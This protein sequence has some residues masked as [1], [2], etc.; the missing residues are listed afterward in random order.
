MKGSD[1]PLYFFGEETL[2]ASRSVPCMSE[3]IFVKEGRLFVLFESAC[4][5]YKTFVRRRTKQIISLPPE[6]FA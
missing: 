4:N 6:F 3:G 2:H 5:K 1:V